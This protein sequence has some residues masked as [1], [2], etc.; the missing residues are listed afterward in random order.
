MI[1]FHKY[2]LFEAGWA[3]LRSEVSHQRCINRQSVAQVT[4]S[5]RSLFHT[6]TIYGYLVK[7]LKISKFEHTSNSSSFSPF[8]LCNPQSETSPSRHLSPLPFLLSTDS[9][10]SKWSFIIFS[11]RFFPLVLFLL[12]TTPTALL[13]GHAE[14]FFFWSP[15][16]HLLEGHSHK[17]SQILAENLKIPGQSQLLI[18]LRSASSRQINCWSDSPVAYILYS[19]FII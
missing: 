15:K 13:N 8:S 6:C 9:S 4:K 5:T 17:V 19:H 18:S 16:R 2:L 1:F 11:P 10:F 12:H 14:H 3:S 7:L